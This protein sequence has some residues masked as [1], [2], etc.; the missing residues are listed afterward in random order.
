MMAY[1]GN[2]NSGSDISK[3][4]R[5]LSKKELDEKDILLSDIEPSLANFLE[6][7]VKKDNAILQHYLT[8]IYHL[9]FKPI[10][11]AHYAKHAAVESTVILPEKF[12]QWKNKWGKDAYPEDNIARFQVI[13]TYG[14]ETKVNAIE[15]WM[16]EYVKPLL[17]GEMKKEFTP[18]VLVC[19]QEMRMSFSNLVARMPNQDPNEDWEEHIRINN[20]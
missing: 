9:L 18:Q 6:G 14:P 10:Q 16:K 3:N 13:L 15:D 5:G 19:L 8:H 7:A 2:P 11:M 1:W 4:F 12:K 20:E 17:K